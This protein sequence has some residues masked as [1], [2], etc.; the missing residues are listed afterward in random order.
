[1]E[2]D[3]LTTANA[4]MGIGII[5]YRYKTI[6]DVG[7]CMDYNSVHSVNSF[8][9]YTPVLIHFREELLSKIIWP[10]YE[11]ESLKQ[12]KTPYNVVNGVFLNENLSNR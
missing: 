6:S 3:T 12:T 4:V 5:G 1:M 10:M 7:T 8:V 9:V 2:L 11:Y